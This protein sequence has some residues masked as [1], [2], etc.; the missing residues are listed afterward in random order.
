MRLVTRGDLDGLAAAVLLSEMEQIEEILLVHPQDITDQRISITSRDLLANLPY[1]P[2]AAM[3]FDHHAHTIK[4]EGKFRGAYAIA[5]SVARVIYNHY[6]SEKLQRFATLVDETDR[7]DS[8][9]LTIDDITNPKGVILLG[10]LIDPRTGMG[11]DFRSLFCSLVERIRRKDVDMLLFEPDIRERIMTL[12]TQ[13]QKFRDFLLSHSTV[14][15]NVVVTDYRNVAHAPAGNRFLV[16]AVFP[17]CNISMRVQWGPEQK[18]VAVNIGHSILN[19]TCDIDVG[20]L[21][22]NYGG[23]GHFGAGACVLGSLSAEL[24]I[25]VMVRKLQKGQYPNLKL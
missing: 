10:F 11:G 17:H 2:Q 14:H 7:F 21:C 8:A 15:N 23:G 5:P 20:E 25:K 1:H 3:W 6:A 9:L 16:Y 24:A 13:D 19:R 4:P 12:Q 18:F 22:R